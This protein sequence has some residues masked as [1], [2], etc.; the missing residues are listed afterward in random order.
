MNISS[1][2]FYLYYIFL[3]LIYLIY[4]MS[5]L[6]LYHTPNEYVNIIHNTFRLIIGIILMITYN[7]VYPL[8]EI[9][10]HHHR[11]AFSAGFYMIFDFIN[12]Y[13]RILF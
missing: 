10:K 12:S 7:P 2:Q 6:N 13:F 1:I 8:E 5:I 4:I 9:K 3:S 11:I